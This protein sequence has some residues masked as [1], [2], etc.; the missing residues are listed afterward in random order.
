MLQQ[1]RDAGLTVKLTKCQFACTQV[2]YLGHIV[3]GREVR[4][5]QVKVEAVL[6]YHKPLTKKDVRA[7]LGLDGYYRKF[8]RDGKC[9]Y[10]PDQE[11]QAR[12][13]SLDR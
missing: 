4:P 8:Y 6:T 2:E 11:E 3:G 5:D 13:G 10:S 12:Q 1:L 9:P 7:F